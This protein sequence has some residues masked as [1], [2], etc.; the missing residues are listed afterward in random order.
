MKPTLPIETKVRK[1]NLS[2]INHA[3]MTYS[4][5]LKLSRLLVIVK[6]SAGL[7]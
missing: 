6:K 5:D 2:T 4:C 7:Q 3:N 1:S